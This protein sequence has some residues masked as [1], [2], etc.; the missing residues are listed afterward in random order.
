[1]LV[2][3][4]DIAADYEQHFDGVRVVAFEHLHGGEV[5]EVEAYDPAEESSGR[6]DAFLRKRYLLSEEP[7]TSTF[8]LLW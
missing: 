6:K 7:E 5:L 8:F 1:M 2:P 3:R 4:P